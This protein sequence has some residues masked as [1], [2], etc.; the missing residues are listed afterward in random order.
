MVVS[1]MLRLGTGGATWGA[2]MDGRGVFEAP[3]ALVGRLDRELDAAMP[4]P[5]R[6]RGGRGVSP[7]VMERASRVLTQ[8][9]SETARLCAHVGLAG[10]LGVMSAH[11]VQ[12]IASM[13]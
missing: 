1:E 13:G 7:E 8:G 11:L 6:Q 9:L 12:L 5:R 10:A 4:R 3:A 2:G